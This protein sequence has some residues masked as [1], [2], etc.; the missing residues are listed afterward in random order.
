L[1]GTFALTF[2]DGPG[3][4]TSDLLDLLAQY[5]AKATFFM[6]G[7]NRGKG[8]IDDESK[9]WPAIIRRMH[10]DG[11]QLASHTWSHANLSQITPEQRKNEVIRLEMALR[12][13]VGFIPTYI[14]P[15]YSACSVASGCP[16][17]LA[18]LGY[19]I[20]YFDFDTQDYIHATTEMIQTSKDVVDALLV[21][22][23][24]K[25]GTYLHISHDIL[26]QTVHNLTVYLLPK[27]MAQGWKL[28]TVGECLNDPKENWYRAA[29]GA[30]SSQ[31]TSLTTTGSAQSPTTSSTAPNTN[32]A[33]TLLPVTLKVIRGK[34]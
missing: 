27:L 19:H 5:G 11:H 20:T 4:F 33:S 17:D 10:A 28:V 1:P 6:T 30:S 25:T 7:V 16:S 13:I 8:Q 21:K 3:E 29:G 34:G 12:N 32:R 9:P 14:R 22:R 18:G 26:F 24:P 2:D 15:P 31:N 23:D